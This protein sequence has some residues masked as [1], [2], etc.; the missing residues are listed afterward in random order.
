MPLSVHGVLLRVAY[1]GAGFHGFARQRAARTVAGEL[2]GAIQAMDPRVTELRGAS[3]TDAGVHARGQLVA[4]DTGKDIPPRGWVLGL[5]S[6][7]P[8]QVAP[9]WAA[10]VP[11]GFDPRHHVAHKHYRY[12]LL[13]DVRRDPFADPYCW[14]LPVTLDLDA[15]RREAADAVG[16]HDFAA[17]RSSSDERTSTTRTILSIDIARALQDPRIVHVDVHGNAFL[18]NMV[19]ILVGT[20]VDVARGRLPSGRIAQ[21]IRSG[22]RSDLGMTAP[23]Q[24]LCLMSVTLDDTASVWEH[25]PDNPLLSEDT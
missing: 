14:R 10:R 19:R 13:Q 12:T 4:F 20:L 18:H 21:A 22:R 5:S 1:D 15:A 2:L 6:H 11:P 3:R 24:G 7:L 25:W 9:R 23:P 8:P 16:T 17:F